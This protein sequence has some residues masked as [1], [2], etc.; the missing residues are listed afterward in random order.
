MRASPPLRI[1]V[2]S[3]RYLERTGGAETVARAGVDALRARGHH[4]EVVSLAETAER[5]GF[6]RGRSSVDGVHRLTPAN[7]YHPRDAARWPVPVRLLWHVR[8]VCAR[9]NA[10]HVRDILREGAFD[11]AVTHNLKGLGLR[12]GRAVQDAG[13]PHV[14]VL[15][16]LQL[17]VPSGLLLHGRERSG[18]ARPALRALYQRFV[19]AALGEPSLVLSFSR[20]LL[21][22]HVAAGFFGTTR[23]EVVPLPRQRP[24]LASPPRGRPRVLF[25]GQLEAHKGV[26]VLLE[27]WTRRAAREAE[28]HVAGDGSLRAVVTAAANDDASIVPQGRLPPERLERL[29]GASD[30]LAAPS[31]CYE[32]AGLSVCEAQAH[33]VFVVASRIGGVSEYVSDGG[34]TLVPPA[35]PRALARALDEPLADLEAL[36][37]RR[38]SIAQGAPGTTVQAHGE[39]LEALLAAAARK[40]AGPLAS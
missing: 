17:C 38:T 8:D 35:D 3:N 6:T 9:R 5:R 2:V 34:G 40:T 28:L 12:I 36:R 14:H 37:A 24:A 25:A 10:A 4:V 19:K 23:R 33:G 11:V 7:L 26:H 30:V 29:L 32:G 1:L 20:F 22:A 39:Q 31:L 27:A 21:D 16:D 13:V 18:D 15:H